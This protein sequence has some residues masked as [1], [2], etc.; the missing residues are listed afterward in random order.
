M[1]ILVNIFI[2]SFI[3]LVQ[4]IIEATIYQLYRLIFG[5]MKADN[6]ILEL[7]DYVFRF[8]VYK[9]G[10]TILAYLALMLLLNEVAKLFIKEVFIRFAIINLFTNVFIVGFI[11]FYLEPFMFD[12]VIF[13]I[14]LIVSVVIGVLLSFLKPFQSVFLKFDK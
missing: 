11:G 2:L 10:M 9:F 12:R 1:K 13:F 3:Y 7:I 14:T 4:N 6:I 8:S 5:T